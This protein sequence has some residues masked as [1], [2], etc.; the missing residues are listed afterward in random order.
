[1][2]RFHGVSP[3]TPY[4]AF[5]GPGLALANIDETLLTPNTAMTDDQLVEAILGSGD[6]LGATDDGLSFSAEPDY[7]DWEFAGVPT[8]I[9]GG[10]R[11][12]SVEAQVEGSFTEMTTQNMKKF[13]PYLDTTPWEIG[14]EAGKRTLGD[15]LEP[16]PYIVDS[17][18]MD[19]VAIIAERQGTMV[20]LIIIIYNAF[21]SE[22][23]ELA[24]EGDENRSSTDVTFMAHYGQQTYDLT[25]GRYGVPYKIYTPEPAVLAITP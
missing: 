22:G 17:D 14:P 24:L 23:F 5:A 2:A 1:M 18:Y 15:I 21:N 25:T 3:Q 12:I 7:Q 4:R 19:N 10:K 16:R 13:V 9:R 8:G 20:P 6:M 11:L